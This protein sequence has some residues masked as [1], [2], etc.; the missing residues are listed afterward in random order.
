MT[1]R[2]A[3]SPRAARPGADADAGRSRSSR[4]RG[5]MTERTR[6]GGRGA[7]RTGRH[8]RLPWPDDPA[9]TGSAP[10][11]ADRRCGALARRTGL[12]V[13]HDFRSADVAAGGRGRAAG[14]C[15]SC[16][17]GG[18]LPQ[19]LA[20]LNIGGV[21]NVTWIG[22]ERR[23][24]R[25]RHRTGQRPTGRLGRSP[26]RQAFDRDGALAA[27]GRVDACGAERLLAD[28]YF[29]RPAPKSLDRLDFA[30]GDR[31]QRPGCAVRRRRR[32]DAS[33]V[34]RRGGRACN[35]AGAAVALAGHAAAAGAI[36]RSWRRCAAASG[37]RS[38]PSRPS[39]GTAM[40]WR[41]SASAFSRRACRRAA[42]QFSRHDRRATARC[43][44]AG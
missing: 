23:A 30:R 40:R 24:A 5:A 15:L 35:V 27:A 3:G 38:I 29:A 16:R 1:R 37:C 2:C 14:A 19:P 33:R 9:P 28:P 13:A 22:A 44:A 26:H 6:R 11:V 7:G 10:D 42:A 25:V 31:S 8:N 18:G 12:P 4:V 43:R 36:R 34:H 32:G 20:V 21:A 41:R 17:A 39:D